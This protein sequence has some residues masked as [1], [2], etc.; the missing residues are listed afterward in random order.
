MPGAA[1]HAEVRNQRVFR[2][3]TTATGPA[4]TG[5]SGS[6]FVY[7]LDVY[8]FGRDFLTP[9]AVVADTRY[10]WHVEADEGDDL[11]AVPEIF[12]RYAGGRAATPSDTVG[13]LS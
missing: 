10:S 11:A 7:C 6:E 5:W 4:S 13:D 2:A 3:V 1:V 9:E 8:R 12:V